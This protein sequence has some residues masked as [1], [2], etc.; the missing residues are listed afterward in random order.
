MTL[1]LSEAGLT[2]RQWKG[3]QLKVGAID[4]LSLVWLV[5]QVINLRLSPKRAFL[6]TNVDTTIRTLA[7]LVVQ[8]VVR[9]V[10]LLQERIPKPSLSEL[11]ILA[12]R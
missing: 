9:K 10:T 4:H 8:A 3:V 1:D 6:P 11:A 7:P 5:G 12:L 2:A